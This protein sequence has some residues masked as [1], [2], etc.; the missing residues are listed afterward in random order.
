MLL[1]EILDFI[2][3]NYEKHLDQAGVQKYIDAIQMGI[4]ALRDR[5]TAPV[6]I[7]LPC[8]PGDTLW[9]V[10]YCVPRSFREPEELLV[11]DIVLLASGPPLIRGVRSGRPIVDYTIEVTV[12]P[13][14][15]GKSVFYSKEAAQRGYE[16][17]G[18]E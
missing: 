13:F 15:F 3:R 6:T 7:G 16:T 11:R 9:H 1:I 12:R 4:D 8:K 10:D 14:D 18:A 17:K 5:N 2:K